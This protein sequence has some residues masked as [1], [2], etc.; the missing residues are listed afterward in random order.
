MHAPG[1]PITSRYT[2]G[3]HDAVN[4]AATA[5]LQRTLIEARR[6]ALKPAPKINNLQ[7]RRKPILPAN[8]ARRRKVG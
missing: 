1:S 3:A 2:L 5:A 7:A 8:P 6:Q 4:R